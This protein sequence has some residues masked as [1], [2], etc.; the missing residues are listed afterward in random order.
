MKRKDLRDC[1]GKKVERNGELYQ[2]ERVTSSGA[3]NGIICRKILD[4]GDL[5]T[6]KEYSFVEYLSGENLCSSEHHNTLAECKL[7]G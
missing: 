1:V 5:D 3:N 4:N 7:I 2:I 6:E